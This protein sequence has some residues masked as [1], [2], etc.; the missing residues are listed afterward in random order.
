[1]SLINPDVRSTVAPRKL[2]VSWEVMLA[3]LGK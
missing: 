1:M 2:A 3:E